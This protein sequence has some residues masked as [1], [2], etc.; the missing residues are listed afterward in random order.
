MKHPFKG[1]KNVYICRA[2][3]HGFVSQDR[4]GG[5]TPF[6]TTCL[7][8]GKL[9]AAS[10]MYRIPQELLGTPAVTW[11]QP[12]KKAWK[13]YAKGIRDHL[14]KGGLIRHDTPTKSNKKAFR[15]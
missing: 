6:L 1:K 10:M 5:V 8:C 12:P 11:L 2:C 14:E 4:D 15:P 3:G 13:N 9:E 7:N